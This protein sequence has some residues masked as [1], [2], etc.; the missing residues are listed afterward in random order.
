ML[1][2]RQEADAYFKRS[3][4]VMVAKQSLAAIN[5]LDKF[6]IVATVSGSGLNSQAG[7]VRHGIARALQKYEPNYRPTLKKAG[8]LTRDAREKERKKCGQPGARKKFQFS[9]R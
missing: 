5:A 1:I 4:S 7:A 8:L 2:N 3:T 6:D 9:K